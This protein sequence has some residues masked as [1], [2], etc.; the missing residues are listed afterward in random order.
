MTFIDRLSEFTSSPQ[1]YDVFSKQLEPSSLRGRPTL[2]RLGF[3]SMEVQYLPPGTS[4]NYLEDLVIGGVRVLQ[5]RGP[6]LTQETSVEQK[7]GLKLVFEKELKTKVPVGDNLPLS[8]FEIR[9]FFGDDPVADMGQWRERAL[10]TAGVLAIVFDERL[11]QREILEDALVLNGDEVA[12][13]IDTRARVRSF[14]P[15]FLLEGNERDVSQLAEL[16]LDADLVATSG[17]KWFLRAVQA[18]PTADAIVFLWIALEAIVENETGNTVAK[19]VTNA[20]TDRGQSLPPDLT[21]GRMY[22]VRSKIVHAGEEPPEMRRS[23]YHLEQITR[24]LLRERLGLKRSWTAT[25]GGIDLPEP[26]RTEVEEA[27]RNPI[28]VM[29]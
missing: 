26:F 18:G 21:I 24:Y 19:K 29:R 22:G 13:V 25:A 27:W 5:T 16:A 1:K 3:Q 15:R 20:L 4:A 6:V 11:V 28:T 23:Y 17:V 8:I 7:P 10:T 2:Y 9:A 14:A 12:G